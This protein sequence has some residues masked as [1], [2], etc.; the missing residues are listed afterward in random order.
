MDRITTPFGFGSTADEVLHGVN[1]DGKH[2]IV[3]GGAS[4]IGIETARA[5]AQVGAG[6][7]L[8]VRNLDAG[9]VVAQLRD[10]DGLGGRDL[11]GRAVTD[12]EGR[13]IF[14]TWRELLLAAAERLRQRSVP[15]IPWVAIR[16]A[17]CSA[18][19]A[20]ARCSRR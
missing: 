17:P 8:A 20:W 3:T 19:A 7:T 9:R 13:Y 15:A 2:A 14:P 4:G 16:S 1:L 18:P 11:V 6:V 12:E 10:V 5:L